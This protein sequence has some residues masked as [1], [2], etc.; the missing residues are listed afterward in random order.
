MKPTLFQR[1]FTDNRPVIFLMAA[2]AT[3][4]VAWT[5]WVILQAV[6]DSPRNLFE[7]VVLLAV[8][9]PVAGCL[10]ALL[11]AFPGGIFLG[12]VLR[13]IER[14]NG[15]PFRKGD[16]VVILSKRHPGRV[17]RVYDVWAARHE[18]RVELDETARKEVTDVFPFTDI[19]RRRAAVE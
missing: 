9:L 14:R 1:L 10:G 16:E 12:I 15:A 18:V 19:C 3:V 11:G 2:G 4:C 7:C 6:A 8:S 17:A 5:A 13:W